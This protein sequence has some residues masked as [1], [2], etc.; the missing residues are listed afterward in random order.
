MVNAT[1]RPIVRDAHGSVV[2]LPIADAVR[3]L[4][5]IL[6]RDLVAVMTGRAPRQVSRWSAG[7]CAPAW[8][9]QQVVRDALQVVRLLQQVEDS[10]VIRAWFMGMNPQLDD[11]APAEAIADGGARDVMAAARTFVDAG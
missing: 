6:G 4:Q 3:D 9:E 10:E 8:H 1:L 7:D 5:E 11:R 2:R